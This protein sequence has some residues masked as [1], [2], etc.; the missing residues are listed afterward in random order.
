MLDARYAFRGQLAFHVLELL[1]VLAEGRRLLHHV[2]GERRGVPRVLQV[3]QFVVVLYMHL[4]RLSF[5]VARVLS[6]VH[7]C[8]L[9]L[10]LV[11]QVP[12]LRI[13]VHS[14]A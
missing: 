11:L 6:L 5:I 1:V 2:G 13:E 10:L 7:V 3:Y 14:V 9:Y 8:R 4:R 12:L